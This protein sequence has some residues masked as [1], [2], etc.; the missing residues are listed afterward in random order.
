MITKAQWKKAQA[1]ELQ[2]HIKDTWRPSPK[3]ME[4]TQKLFEYFA[5]S[6]ERWYGQPILDLGAGSMLRSRYFEGAIIHALE[7]LGGLFLERI[8]SCDLGKADDLNFARAEQ[9]V[10][11]WE[12]KMDF[13]M[14]I[15]VLDHC[16]DPEMV[17][18]NAHRYLRPGDSRFLLSVDTGTIPDEMHPIPITV[19]WLS[20]ECA[21]LFRFKGVKIGLPN[22]KN[23]GG[24][25]KAYTMILEPK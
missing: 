15:N 8:P 19:E 25:G 12:G 10:D 20:N 11:K 14:C 22:A 21:K 9:F 24:N 3:F 13:V 5:Y 23:Y 4:D 16:H 1:A 6:P 18:Q 17:L 2:F 7:P